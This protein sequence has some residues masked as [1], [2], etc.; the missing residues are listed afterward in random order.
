MRDCA[1]QMPIVVT[2]LLL[3]CDGAGRMLLERLQLWEESQPKQDTADRRQRIHQPQRSL[4]EVAE[5]RPEIRRSF[6]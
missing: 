4:S 1:P 5:H 2:D 3:L 6:L